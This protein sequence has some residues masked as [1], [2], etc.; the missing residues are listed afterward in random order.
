[1]G[2]TV[3][4][5]ETEA[6]PLEDFCAAVADDLDML[7]ALHDREPDVEFIAML[8]QFRFP[9]GLGLLLESERGRQSARLLAEALETMPDRP[10]SELLDELA[11]DYTSIY[12]THAIQASPEESVWIDEEHLICQESM[13]QVRECYR[14]HGLVAPDWRRR[15]DDHLVL[16]LQF[17]GQLFQRGYDEVRLAEAAQFLDEHL[18]RW[19]GRFATRV[20]HRCATPYFAGCALLTEAYC[21]ELRDLLASLLGTPRPTPEEIEERMKPSRTEEQVPVRFVPGV[22]PAV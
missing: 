13:F 3:F 20:A 21:E 19:L 9:E 11:A 4:P 15:P 22:G 5:R 1:M 18:L 8:R 12:L 17:I 7:A 10:G 2:S 16:E 14:R 6:S